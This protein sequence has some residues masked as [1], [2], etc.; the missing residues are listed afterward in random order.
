MSNNEI[1]DKK[2]E[3]I[4]EKQEQ[5]FTC[6]YSPNEKHS[7]CPHPQTCILNKEVADIYDDIKSNKNEIKYLKR[8]YDDA[9]DHYK[10]TGESTY[11]GFT[12]KSNTLQR[13]ILE[14]KNKKNYRRL[15]ELKTKE[16]GFT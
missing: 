13:M 16:G 12:P 3:L 6:Y 2:W 14:N 5:R 9:I 10:E 15:K 4:H 7:L 11:G 1:I 8:I